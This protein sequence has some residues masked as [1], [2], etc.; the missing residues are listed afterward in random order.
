MEAPTEVMIDIM[1]KFQSGFVNKSKAAAA[2]FFGHWTGE[3]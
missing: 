2:A 3:N 1:E